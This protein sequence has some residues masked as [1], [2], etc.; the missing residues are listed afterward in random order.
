MTRTYEMRHMPA[1][2]NLESYLE[3]QAERIN[4]LEDRVSGLMD[5]IIN[6]R[7]DS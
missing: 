1:D 6:H 5:L 3:A 4:D 7:H 2:M